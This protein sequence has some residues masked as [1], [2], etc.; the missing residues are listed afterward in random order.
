MLTFL[1]LKPVQLVLVYS[2]CIGNF[3]SFNYN[4]LYFIL[5]FLY[6][7]L[8]YLWDTEP[9]VYNPCIYIF[10]FFHDDYSIENM[11][12]RISDLYLYLIQK[13]IF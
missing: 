1:L 2:F 12:G 7:C 3:S 8:Y 6:I 4:N 11:F 5:D 13:E 10:F 9:I